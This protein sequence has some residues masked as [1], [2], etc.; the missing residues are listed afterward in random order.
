MKRETAPAPGGEFQKEYQQG[1]KLVLTVRARWPRQ[2]G[3]GRG[4]RQVERYY[5]ALADRWLR[6]WSGPLLAQAKEAA[7][8]GSPPWRAELDYTVTLNAGELLSFRLDAIEDRGGQRRQVR[9][10]DIWRMPAGEPLSLPDVL[11]RRRWWRSLVLP[12]V[13]RQIGSAVQAGEGL[14]YDGWESLCSQWLSPDRAYL[15]EEGPVIFYPMETIA[16]ALEGF[17]T[18]SLATLLP[19]EVA[20]AET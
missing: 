2:P 10:G 11:P 15:T 3:E 5:D 19:K 7:A 4:A 17:P 8:G 16:P 13:R 12:E 14:Y 18:F 9:M 1:G 6:R 20:A